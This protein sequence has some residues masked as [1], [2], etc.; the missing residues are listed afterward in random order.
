MLHGV[1]PFNSFELP[2]AVAEQSVHLTRFY[3][4]TCPPPAYPSK[5]R[6][7]KGAARKRPVTLPLVSQVKRMRRLALCTPSG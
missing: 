5:S 4:E 6:L 2:S 1:V 3:P 7:R